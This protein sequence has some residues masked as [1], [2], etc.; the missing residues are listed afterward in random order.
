MLSKKDI[1]IGLA[2]HARARK[3]AAGCRFIGRRQALYAHPNHPPATTNQT[4]THTHHAMPREAAVTVESSACVHRQGAAAARRPTN[5]IIIRFY[6][7]Y[8]SKARSCCGCRGWY[9]SCCLLLHTH[10]HTHPNECVV[11]GLARGGVS[12]VLGAVSF[13]CHQ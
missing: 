2:W 5:I 9:C 11:L 1:H 8:G 3:A 7:R 6:Y 12:P 4:F 10:T 13:A